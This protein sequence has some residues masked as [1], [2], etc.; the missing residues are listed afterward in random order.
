[1]TDL[2]GP[3]GAARA[4]ASRPSET[5]APGS[6]DTFFGDCVAGVPGTGTVIPA[7]WLNRVSA[8]FRRL[9][10]GSG[11]TENNLDDEMAARAV[12]SQRLNATGVVG[13]TA[14]A[15][16]LTFTPAF[17]SEASLAHVPLRFVTL[18]ANTGPVTLTVDG[19]ADPLTWPDGTPLAAGDLPAGVAVEVRHDS[20]AY[21]L[22]MATTAPISTGGNPSYR[23]ISS[24][25]L[26]SVGSSTVTPPDGAKIGIVELWGGGGGSTASDSTNPVNGAGGGGYKRGVIP[27]SGGVAVA[28]TI[29][30]GGAPAAFGG[31]G[32]TGG[33]TTIGGISANGGAG[34][35]YTSVG[36]GGIGGSGGTLSIGG[37]S[38]GAYQSGGSTGGGGGAAARGGSGGG[39]SDAGAAS[40]GIQP[41]GGAGGPG[42]GSHAGK[43]GGAGAIYIE[44]YG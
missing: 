11:V 9:V 5:A 41:G 20:A 44:W 24:T 6:T 28:Y 10:R 33:T 17:P 7:T 27:V 35:S 36:G 30:A 31:T 29:G 34:S 4:L 16:T 18:A 32:A 37:Q 43:S 8:Q 21:R 22:T 26:S 13:G 23:Y 14:N 15:I 3:D 1:M 38:G 25:Y 19:V 42:T 2:M 39:S 12:R 40:D